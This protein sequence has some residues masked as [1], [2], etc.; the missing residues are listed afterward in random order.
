M[1]NTKQRLNHILLAAAVALPLLSAAGAARTE[2]I[3][4][5]QPPAMGGGEHGGPGGRSGPGPAGSDRGPDNGPR[6]AGGPDGLPPGFGPGTGFGPGP[7]PDSHP[8]LFRGVELSEAQEDKIFAILHA[9]KPYLREQAKVA[10]KADEALQA[11]ATADKYDDAKAASLAQAVA[12]ADANIALQ[13]VRTRQK[14]LAVL[15]PE[16]RQKQAEQRK[17]RDDRQSEGKPR[18]PRG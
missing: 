2:E 9:E 13:H 1:K 11:L 7:G 12:T 3:H 10:A 18:R 8:P 5:E 15:T 4:G 16:Q 17:E 14:L 6:G